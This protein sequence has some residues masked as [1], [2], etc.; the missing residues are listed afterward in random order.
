MRNFLFRTLLKKKQIVFRE[1]GDTALH[2]IASLT[3][4]SC[5]EETM[6]QMAEIATIIVQKGADINRQNRK[7]L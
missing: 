7:G 5:D 2:L 1:E 3:S 6:E 4:S